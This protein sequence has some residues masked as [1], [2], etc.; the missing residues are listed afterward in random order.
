MA[1]LYDPTGSPLLSSAAVA[2]A[3]NLGAYAE[4]AERLQ[5]LRGT[6]YRGE[7][8]ETAKLVVVFQV[9]GLVAQGVTLSQVASVGRG[10]RSISYKTDA[11]GKTIFLD[12][13]ASELREQLDD[14]PVLRGK[15]P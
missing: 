11:G 10:A 15:V 14:W 13:R 7:D 5:R 12:E 2:L 4:A 8:A 3:G 6:R 9:N 1:P